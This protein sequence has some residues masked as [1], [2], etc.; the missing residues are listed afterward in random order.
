MNSLMIVFMESFR[1]LCNR[2]ILHLSCMMQIHRLTIWT[3]RR[4]TFLHTF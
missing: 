4:K 2:P 3:Y 1:H